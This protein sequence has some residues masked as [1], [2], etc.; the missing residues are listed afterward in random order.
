MNVK[1]SIISNDQRLV[2]RLIQL[3][4]FLDIRLGEIIENPREAYLK[5]TSNEPR[6][7]LFVEPDADIS[8]DQIVKQVKKVNITAPIIFLSK[9]E[10][11]QKARHLFRSGVTDILKYPDEVDDLEKAIEKAMEVIKKNLQKLEQEQAVA[12]DGHGS[13]FTFYSGKGG[14]GASIIGANFAQAMAFEG[15]NVLF[16]DLNL[17]FGG[18]QDLFS[19]ANHNRHLGNLKPVINEL[20]EAQIRNV[21]YT[22]PD[23]KLHILLAPCSPEEAELFT[24]DDIESLLTSCRSYY[25]LV[26]LDIPKELNEVSISGL[27]HTDY[28]FYVLR[29]ERPS[30]VT[31]QNVLNLLERYHLVKAG[32][33]GLIINRFDKKLDLGIDELQKMTQYPLIGTIKDDYKSIQSYI[34][35][36]VPWY[37]ELKRKSKKGPMRDLLMV[38][39]TIL[40]MVGE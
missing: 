39:S 23:S 36:G 17:Q 2:Q 5:I 26:I 20:T 28:L 10:D 1:I 14:S 6:I 33:V 30:I 16:I 21:V 3:I 25:D 38:K 12:R 22:M 9:T 7:V 11:F 37:N 35:F 32:S 34:N 4:D 19:I 18:I 15:Y 13:V 40:S 24:S 31:M 27:N 29:L 8:I